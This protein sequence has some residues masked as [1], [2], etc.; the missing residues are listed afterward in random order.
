LA[1]EKSPDFKINLG[2]I[3]LH[4]TAEIITLISTAVWV[5]L[6]NLFD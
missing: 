4:T 1:K 3:G 2:S 6:K 5:I